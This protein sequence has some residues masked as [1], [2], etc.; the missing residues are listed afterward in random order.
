MVVLVFVLML[1][2]GTVE[3]IEEPNDIVGMSYLTTGETETSG[4]CPSWDLVFSRKSKDGPDGM[5]LYVEVDACQIIVYDVNSVE[6]GTPE[7]VTI[8]MEKDDYLIVWDEDSGHGSNE[9]F[10]FTGSLTTITDPNAEPIQ[11][12]SNNETINWV[13][14]KASSDGTLTIT[15]TG[16]NEHDVVH[17]QRNWL[18]L[19]KEVVSVN[20]S[21]D[22]SCIEPGDTVTYEICW[23][24]NSIFTFEDC[25]LV[26][27]LPEEV[28]YPGS[29]WTLDP[30]WTPVPPDPAYDPNTHTYI[31]LDLGTISPDD[32]NCVELT[33]EVNGQAEPEMYLHNAA[34]LYA[35]D[36]Y[37]DSNSL[38]ARATVDTLV[39]CWDDIDPNI[40]YVDIAATGDDN[41]TDW[42][43]AYTD[44]DDAIRRA[45]NSNCITNPQIY[46]A[47]GTYAPQDTENGYLLSDNMSVYGGFKS[48]DTFSQRK[49]KKYETILTGDFDDDGF[50]DADA[51]VTMGDESLI[52]GF[53]V[54]KANFGYAENGNVTVKWC[55][56][57][58]NDSS[59]IRH[60]GTGFTLTV[61]NS[62]ILRNGEYG[63][64]GEKSTPTVKN[65]IISESD[66]KEYGRAGIRL[67]RPTTKPVLYNNTI[68]NNKA[69]GIYFEDDRTLS[70]P[71]DKDWPD[72]QNCIVY[73]NN[74]GG[75]QLSTGLDDRPQYSCIQDC[76]E[77]NSNRSD[78]PGFAYTVDPNG[79][80][81][82]E[83]YHLAYDSN[84][85]DEGSLL[86]TYTN[87]VDIDGEG[88]NRKSGDAVDIGAD[89]VYS[90]GGSYTEDE[91]FNEAD[92]NA[93]GIINF[94]EFSVFSGA[95]LS[96]DPNGPGGDPNGWNPICNLDA[97]GTSQYVIDLDD[98]IAFV[99]NDPQVWL[100][101]AC[102][103]DD[104]LYGSMAMGGGE[105]MMA[106]PMMEPMSF[107]DAAFESVEETDPY[108]A[109]SSDEVVFL[110]VGIHHVIDHIEI[111][112]EKDHENAEK[113]TEA[114]DF[115]E[116][117]LADI[118]AARETA[119]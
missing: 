44:L 107:E 6:Q 73:Y 4:P 65:S 109:M 30:N 8:E 117:V 90:C 81:N 51:V 97:S 42:T 102:W 78:E 32:A 113:L 76:N 31:Y 37:D 94:Y 84:C 106:A 82:P 58:L 21:N 70:N 10:S 64:W 89:E 13:I 36:P 66:L 39:C 71:T 57:L 40:I 105:S 11:I 116:E 38:I 92:W 62:W 19:S 24:N 50:P 47:Q 111:S 56:V 85:I 95:W 14:H 23:D 59:G 74:G 67:Y 53:T 63:I 34:D 88:T 68:S 100:W 33:V 18:E 49:P 28:F 22:F 20:D 86:L 35:T 46:V 41:G 60:D 69:E 112:L 52:G 119:P 5:Y 80:P 48:G 3:A 25:Y 9:Y 17:L 2:I 93:D 43:N 83:N 27:Y 110:V 15:D 26:D 79:T 87:Q 101:E 45:S 61:E 98:L 12:S 72:I 1:G 16:Q 96:H 75:K 7:P 104:G 55:K 108:A 103:R 77:V 91:F 54:T 114:K 29:V 118:R 115:L 99:E